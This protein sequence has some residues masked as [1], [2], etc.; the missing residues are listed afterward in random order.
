MRTRSRLVALTLFGIAM[1]YMEGAVVAYLRHLY[2]DPPSRLFP[3]AS[4]DPHLYMIELGREVATL[5]M[6]GA[7]AYLSSRRNNFLRRLLFFLFAF[8]VWDITYYI[9][10][11]WMIGWPVHWTD[12]DILFLI[13]LPWFAPFLAPVLVSIMFIVF[14][15][16]VLL[17]NKDP[18]PAPGSYAMGVSGAFIMFL[19]FIWE[20]LRILAQ[21]GK[22]GFLT[23]MPG[24]FPW[25]VFL[26]GYAGMLVGFLL[27]VRHKSH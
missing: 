8:G 16:L 5:V 21:E 15:S 20:P 2:Y 6:L 3:L 18:K 10:L 11:R 19:S 26:L 27:L 14:S 22:D 25:P 1:G 13:P 9:W 23:Y 7:V 12:W 24:N 4:F 17:R